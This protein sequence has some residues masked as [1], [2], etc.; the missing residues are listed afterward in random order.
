MNVSHVYTRFSA[1]VCVRVRGPL[2]MHVAVCKPVCPWRAYACSWQGVCELCVPVKSSRPP[3]ESSLPVGL[4]PIRVLNRV[5]MGS[6][7]WPTQPSGL[8]VEVTPLCNKSVNGN[9]HSLTWGA[10]LS[11]SQTEDMRSVQE[12]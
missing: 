5:P 4:V 7:G 12:E 11:G 1:C 9:T 2:Y 3:A 10:G 8:V 6:R